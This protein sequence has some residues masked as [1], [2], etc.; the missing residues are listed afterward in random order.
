M[1]QAE[2]SRKN[3]PQAARVKELIAQRQV[4]SRELA[5]R[6]SVVEELQAELGRIESDVKVVRARQ[7]R[8]AALLQTAANAKD[9]A[10]LEHELAS[11]QRRQR[12]LEDGELEVMERLEAAEASVAEQAR[13]VAEANEEGGRLS[14]EAKAVVADAT[15]R[16]EELERDR[17]AV[18][19]SLPSDLLALYDESATRSVGAAL[20]RART[21]TGCHMMLSGTD[22]NALRQLADDAVATCPECG[23]ILVRTNESGL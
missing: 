9:I 15:S 18:A 8:D 13:L 2:H 3:P 17:A 22:L 11:L 14:A 10:G 4:L 1:R 19:A 6:Q 5:D 12:E 23:T 7:D 21:C 20:L 16:K